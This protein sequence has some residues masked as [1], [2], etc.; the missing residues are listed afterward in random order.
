MAGPAPFSFSADAVFRT[1]QLEL[2]EAVAEKR[3]PG[4]YPDRQYVEPTGS[5]AT[6]RR[7]D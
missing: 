5:C 1:V 4:M 2:L 6:G 3:L 7:G